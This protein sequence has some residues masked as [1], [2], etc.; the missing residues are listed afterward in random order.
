MVWLGLFTSLIFVN[1]IGVAL[2]TGVAT[3]QSWSDAYEISS[4]ALI[5]E[6]LGPLGGWGKFC[7][8]IL[9]LGGIANNA[10]PTYSAALSIQVL[11]RYA[12]AV[13]RWIWCLV[14]M[15]VELVCAVAGRNSLFGVFENFLPLMAYWSTPWVTIVFLEHMLFHKLRKVPFDWTAWEDKKR[16]PLGGAALLSFL[17]GWVGAIVGMAQV[18]YTGP[19]A[20]KIGGYGGDV[21]AWL[22]I[23]FVLVTFPPLRYLELKMV[24]H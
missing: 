15:I 10:P 11:G 4:G 9:A 14:L 6:A 18:W 22:A 3:T 7:A 21:G 1:L 5:V 12:K 17:I 19:I 16:L 13:P 8:V 23:A 20:L 2:A 24:G